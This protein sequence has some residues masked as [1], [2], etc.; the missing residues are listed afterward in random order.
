MV[1]RHSSSSVMDLGNWRAEQKGERELE[2][3]GRESS[4]P[5]KS[6]QNNFFKNLLK[7]KK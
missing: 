1:G 2:R 5:T 7:K 6:Y 3:R 4:G